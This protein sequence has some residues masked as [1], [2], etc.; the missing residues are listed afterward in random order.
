MKKIKSTFLMLITICGILGTSCS[1]ES[2]SKNTDKD[3][4][5]FKIDNVLWESKADKEWGSY[6]LDFLGG[7]AIQISG[8]KGD[9]PNDQLFNINIYN[10]DAEGTYTF[11]QNNTD[12]SVAQIA[13]LSDTKILCGGSGYDYDFTVVVTKVSKTPQIVEATFNG[14]MVCSDGSTIRITDG[15]FSY[16]E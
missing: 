2:A 16:H 5:S 3:F 13:Q 6:H 7:T 15:K 11:N 10:T 8:S 9:E 12:N 4:L 1:N 14:T